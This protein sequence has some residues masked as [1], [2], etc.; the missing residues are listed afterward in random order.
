MWPT[1]RFRHMWPIPLGFGTCV[2]PPF[3]FGTCCLRP[4]FGTC[5][6]LLLVSAHVAYSRDGFGTC[7]LLPGRGTEASGSCPDGIETDDQVSAHV[8]YSRGGGE[9]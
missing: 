6:L 2:L 7:G 5:G 4:G 9:E 8:A 3:S 1:P